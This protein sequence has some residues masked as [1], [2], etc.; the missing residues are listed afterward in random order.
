VTTK[1]AICFEKWNNFIHI[2]NEINSITA[3]IVNRL[4][5]RADRDIISP[6]IL[7]LMHLNKKTR[8]QTRKNY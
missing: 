8:E 1:N 6:E 2:I 4:R 5:Q 3:G 7:H